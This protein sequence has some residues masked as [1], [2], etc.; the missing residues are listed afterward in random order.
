VTVV[1]AADVFS[2]SH[3]A[4]TAVLSGVLAVAIGVWRF[5][6]PRRFVDAGI[7]GVIAAGRGVLVA[8]LGE[9]SPTQP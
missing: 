7:V 4:L 1:G 9:S 6:G 3:I 2:R 5:R 8:G